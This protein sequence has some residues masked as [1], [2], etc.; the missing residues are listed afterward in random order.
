[1]RL[2]MLELRTVLQGHFAPDTAVPGTTGSVP[3]AGHCAAV[4]YIAYRLDPNRVLVSAKVEGQSH[5]FIRE[6]GIDWDITA[7]QFGKE[8]I[9][10][11]GNGRL[12][13]ETRRRSV[14]EVNE[15]TRARARL[16]AER[17]GLYL[18]ERE[19]TP[20]YRPLAISVCRE[21]VQ[22]MRERLPR[23]VDRDG[24]FE[25]KHILSDITEILDAMSYIE[26]ARSVNYPRPDDVRTKE[27]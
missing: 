13:P 5:W 19:E 27:K 6:M 14:A 2:T 21:R 18:D 15:E 8:P 3:S 23:V 26:Y 7:D 25:V 1:M 24:L 11:A 10:A 17:S 9:A 22:K 4:A 20:G 12:Y 16:L